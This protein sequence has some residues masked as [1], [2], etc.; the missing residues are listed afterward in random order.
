MNKIREVP[1]WRRTRAQFFEPPAHAEQFSLS[2]FSS[3]AVKPSRYVE[4]AVVDDLSETVTACPACGDQGPALEHWDRATCGACGLE[5]YAA[6][7]SLTIWRDDSGDEPKLRL[8]PAPK[9]A[10]EQ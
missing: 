8:L 10:E 4:G 6:G 2:E 7:N 1:T 5:M 3:H 9:E